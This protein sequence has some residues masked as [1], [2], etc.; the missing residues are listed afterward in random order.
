MGFKAFCFVLVKPSRYQ[1]GFPTSCPHLTP[2]FRLRIERIEEERHSSLLCCFQTCAKVQKLEGKLRK[3]PEMMTFL[4]WDGHETGRKQISQDE[5]EVSYTEADE[6]VHSER[7][8]DS[9]ALS[10]MDRRR[11][12]Y[13]V[14][15]NV[16]FMQRNV[17]V[18]SFLLHALLRRHLLSECSRYFPLVVSASDR[19]T[20]PLCSSYVKKGKIPDPIFWTFSVHVYK[21]LLWL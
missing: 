8:Q 11:C 2:G 4:T 16:W 6:D 9:R 15:T 3:F 14:N 10:V 13:A 5:K 19:D 20:V 7:Q 17:Y 1:Q 21:Q 12:R 18:M